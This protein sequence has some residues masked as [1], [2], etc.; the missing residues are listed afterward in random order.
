MSEIEE[1][2]AARYNETVWSVGR[3]ALCNLLVCWWQ[4]VM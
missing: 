1:H 3:S 4:C 2:N